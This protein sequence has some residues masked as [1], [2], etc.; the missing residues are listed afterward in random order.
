MVKSV[1]D[2]IYIDNE[3]KMAART[4]SPNEHAYVKSVL[5]SGA[6]SSLMGGT[7]TP[8]F[9]QAFADALGCKHA[10][11]MSSCMA[12]L[13]SAV[14]A[15]GA[16]AG[17]EVIC[18]SMYIFGAMSVLYNNAI[19]VFVDIDPITQNMDPDK[20]EAAVTE[21]TKA[22]IVTH[23][24]GLPAEMDR[25]N[26]VAR[27]HG[28][29]VIEDC[30][31]AVLAKYK[32]RY[33]GTWGD[34]GCFSFQASKQMPLGDGG[35]ATANDPELYKALANF[36]GAPTF[37]SIAYGLDYNYRINEP[38]AAIGLA[39]LETLHACID[40]L[41]KNASYYDQAVEG[42]DWITLQRGPAEAEH[43]FY[44]WAAN[45]TGDDGNGPDFEDFKK[46]VKEAEFSS[47]T[48][49]YTQIPAYKHPLIA[50]RKA[51]AFTDPRNSVCRMEYD[52]GLC[53]VA[54]QIIPRIILGYVVEPEEAAKQEA[55]KLH[56]LIKR[57][58]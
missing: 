41:K 10:V 50:E 34:I 4:A 14:I 46:A 45:F 48:I 9:E 29:V 32:G 23:A 2:E 25:I 20:I 30:A 19:P 37:L 52:A 6:L 44:Y 58:S 40:Q 22:I 26:S 39:K 16:G 49:G 27:K 1:N 55:Q 36:A 35:M 8:R 33:T 28:L 54:E 43:S 3:K 24:W 47:I 12:A 38:T 11:A 51:Q 13:H 56:E 31:E 21:R 15:A 18:D 17:C 57:L 5:D 53:P 42:C 7:Y